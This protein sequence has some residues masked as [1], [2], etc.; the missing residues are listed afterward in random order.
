MKSKGEQLT[1]GQ[2]PRLAFKQLGLPYS[3]KRARLL[4]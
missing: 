2:V 4:T 3:P 1:A